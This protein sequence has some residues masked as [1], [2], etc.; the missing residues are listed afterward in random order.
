MKLLLDEIK[1][2]QKDQT[3]IKVI[4]E[5]YWY[6]RKLSIIIVCMINID[7]DKMTDT[8]ATTRRSKILM[9]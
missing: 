5:T 1:G 4:Q 2:V 7:L 6:Y 9:I 3:L 8:L